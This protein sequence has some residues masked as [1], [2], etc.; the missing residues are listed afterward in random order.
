MNRK[1][2]HDADAAEELGMKALMIAIPWN[3]IIIVDRFCAHEAVYSGT[4]LTQ[5]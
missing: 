5:Y 1:E 3:N 2:D 4:K